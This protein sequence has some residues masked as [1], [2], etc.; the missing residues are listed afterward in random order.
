MGTLR[1]VSTDKS[2]RFINTV[3][4]V[5]VNNKPRTNKTG[6]LLMS[7]PSC[8]KGKIGKISATCFNG[9]IGNISATCFKGKT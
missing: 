8:F 6:P 9:K 4:I 5:I 2:V 3:I 7:H 1:I